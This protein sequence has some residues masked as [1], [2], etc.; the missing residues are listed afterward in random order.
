[1]KFDFGVH[2]ILRVHLIF[3]H[4]I[5]TWSRGS[6]V[7]IVSGYELDDREIEVWSPAEA[8]DFSLTCVQTDS[9]AQ[10][11]SCT[12]G[13]GDAFSGGKARQGRDADH[14]PPSNAEVE[15]E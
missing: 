3:I 12:M 10:P 13:T 1:M 14:S 15:D 4:T 9:G 2:I 11:A 8:K 5:A 6:S 7:S